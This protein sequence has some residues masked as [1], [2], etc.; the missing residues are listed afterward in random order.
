MT[1]SYVN[2]G[3]FHTA[4]IPHP[5]HSSQQLHVL[6]KVKMILLL[7]IPSALN[8]LQLHARHT[9]LENFTIL[10]RLAFNP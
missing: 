4:Y 3:N 7:I 8:D 10:L 9:F 1:S 2:D 6:D 5:F